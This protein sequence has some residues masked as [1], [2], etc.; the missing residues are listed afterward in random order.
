MLEDRTAKPANRRAFFIETR[1]GELIGRVGVFSI[2][3]V[4]KQGELGIVIGE[5]AY[6]AKGYG[7]DTI[8][9]LLHHIF[10]STSLVS[11]NLFTFTDNV[12]A[13]RCF[14]ACGFRVVGTGK[15]FSPD[16]GEFEGIEMEITRDEFLTRPWRK[17]HTADKSISQE[18]K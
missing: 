15:R 14:A 3:W 10:K 11:V 6:W 2:D 4:L 1:S 18:Q 12:R 17:L 5:H 7:R 8:M 16:I 13:Q 9:T